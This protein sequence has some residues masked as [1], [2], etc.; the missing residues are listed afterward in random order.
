M[1]IK[2]ISKK[3]F[4][5]FLVLL[6][7]II[8]LLLVIN[9]PIINL[10]NKTSEIDYSNWMSEN[11]SN[12]QLI[13]DIA[14]LGA[15]DAFSNEINIF[16]KLDPYEDNGIMKGFTGLLVKGFIVKQS[17]TQ[18][19]K[20]QDLLSKGVRYLDVRLTYTDNKWYTKHNYLS[21]DFE[22]VASQIVDFLSNN[23]GEFLILDFQHISGLDYS[24]IDDY[25]IFKTMLDS[26]GLL[27]YAY[28]VNNLSTLNYGEL[29]NNGTKSKLIITSKFDHSSIEVLNYSDSVRSNWADS[30][31][32]E[33]IL[34]FIKEDASLVQEDNI[35]DKLRVMQGVVTMQMDQTGLVN[36]LTSWSLINR[37]KNFNNYLIES[38]DFVLLLDNLPIIM[39][40]YS[41]T[42][43]L[44]FNDNVMELIIDFNGN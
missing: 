3:I 20:A 40:D 11:L 34:E 37:A 5:I 1:K 10:S 13:V 9:I 32:F 35:N 36:A 17:V 38:R 30:D 14:M 21:S 27:D 12:D 26:Y 8:S 18:V 23:E 16:S 41:N 42:N 28:T 15:H 4:K 2:L 22:S 31:D 29:T 19:A 25:N 7:F 39:V 44:L 6:I 24:N 43:Y 33:Y